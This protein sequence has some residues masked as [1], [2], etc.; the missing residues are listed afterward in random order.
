MLIKVN[1]LVCRMS[2]QVSFMHEH[3]PHKNGVAF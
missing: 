2:K 3:G 1:L